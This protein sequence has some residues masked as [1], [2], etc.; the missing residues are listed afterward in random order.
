MPRNVHGCQHETK[1][2]EINVSL[3]HGQVML[4][5]LPWNSNGEGG[6]GNIARSYLH[7]IATNMKNGDS[8]NIR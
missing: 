4:V 2:L 1:F 8:M 5:I 7:G 3:K 6:G